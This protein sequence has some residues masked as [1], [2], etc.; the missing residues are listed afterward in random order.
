M[1]ILVEIHLGTMMTHLDPSALSMLRAVFGMGLLTLVMALWMSVVRTRAMREHGVSLQDAAHTAT[2]TARL[3]SS[4]TRLADNYKHLLETP[5]LFYAVVL[6]IV[7]GGIASPL[8]AGCAWAFLACRTLHS[9]VQA[10]FN[11]VW[12]RAS[13]YALS[14]IALAILIV[15]PILS[16]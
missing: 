9:L 6:A 5:T 11:R 10:T 3:P 14:W 13:L 4:A 12:I 1:A 16:L 7:V 2:L 8:Y 15:R